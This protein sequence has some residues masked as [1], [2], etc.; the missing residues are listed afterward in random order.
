MEVVEAR[1][2]DFIVLELKQNLGSVRKST[3]II[4]FNSAL[5][6]EYKIFVKA[7]P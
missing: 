1:N 3:L 6:I 2:D 5:C 4:E 7:E